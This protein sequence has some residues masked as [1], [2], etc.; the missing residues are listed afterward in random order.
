M[1]PAFFIYVL[2]LRRRV[3]SIST[4][5]QRS[6]EISTAIVKRFLHSTPFWSKWKRA[7]SCFTEN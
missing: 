2:S 4:V 5:V 1:V 6:G 7:V 3:S